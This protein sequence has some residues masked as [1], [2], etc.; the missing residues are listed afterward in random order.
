[1][2]RMDR[3]DATAFAARRVW[4]CAAVVLAAA[5]SLLVMVAVPAAAEPSARANGDGRIGPT[6]NLNAA[7]KTE[8]KDNSYKLGKATVTGGLSS[9]VVI[10]VDNGWF[11]MPRPSIGEDADAHYDVSHALDAHGDF[12]SRDEL[13]RGEKHTFGYRYVVFES[14]RT[15]DITAK[16]IETHL[17]SLTF[18]LGGSKTQTVSVSAWYNQP[19]AKCNYRSGSSEDDGRN[20][21]AR[22]FNGHAYAFIEEPDMPFDEAF[23]AAKV[24]TFVGSDGHL[25][26]IE[27]REEHNL[28]H[29]LFE[30]RG[31]G[32]GWIGGQR[33]I[34]PGPNRVSNWYWVAGPSAGIKFW[35]GETGAVPGVFAQWANG[36]PSSNE[37]A[38]CVQYGFSD[39]ADSSAA[40]NA[41]TVSGQRAGKWS[42]GE[43]TRANYIRG[44]YVEF[45]NF[46]PSTIG[47]ASE[48]SKMVA[49]KSDLLDVTSSN[50]DTSMLSG[51]EY[52]TTLTAADGRDLD[53]ASIQVMVG[54]VPLS[55]RDNGF[56]FNLKSDK[57]TAEL[58]IPA[59]KVTGDVTVTAKANRLVTLQD[60]WTSRV[61]AIVQV[62]NGVTL[63]RKDLDQHVKTKAGYT[64][65]G[66]TK[67]GAEWDFGT[68]VTVDMT[69]NPQ[70]KL[71]APT[72][73]IW[74]PDPRLDRR[75]ATVTLHVSA[76]VDGVPNA[77]FTY[78]W[79]KDG[80]ALPGNT[81][82]TLAATDAGTYMVGVTAT[83][84]ATKLT[85]QGQAT[86]EVTA[87]HQR[88]VTLQ[89]QDGFSWLTKQFTVTN[90]DKL[91]RN[92]L[93]KKV[94]WPGYTVVEY[95]KADGTQ[96]PFEA[97]VRSDVTLHPQYEMIAPTVT[98]TASPSKLMSVGDKSTLSA[99]V[100]TLVGN[101]E[102]GY[103]WSKGGNPIAG[104]TG[105]SYKT[106]EP[107]DYMVTVTVTDP[108]TN[109]SSKGTASVTLAAPDRHMVT[110][111][112]QDGSK[113]YLTVKVP[114]GGLLDA[115]M[116]SG[117][118]RDGHVLIGWMK[119]DGTKFD[120]T[121][122]KITQ[123][124]VI[125]PEWKLVESAEPVKP[126][127]PAKPTK[128]AEPAAKTALVDTGLAVSA[129]AVALVLMLV[130][131]VVA[132]GLR[133]RRD[134]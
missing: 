127:K 33:V 108:K 102:I 11:E 65:V 8:A 98:A 109:M 134:K 58:K 10:E 54:G 22:L 57:R 5:A 69:L 82:G 118:T 64:H 55:Q 15:A 94:T 111:V 93:D 39:E 71:K 16:A 84:P 63:E 92:D 53:P 121:Q 110:V 20:P 132:A 131:A 112:E 128:P 29:R 48:V 74:T 6:V 120:P 103:Q 61:L 40:W 116:L 52:S 32:T 7:Q 4:R 47:R 117:I 62:P 96:W 44:F 13:S 125:S 37:D 30:K 107:G 124:E 81:A 9:Y 88:T 83:D 101:G 24:T 86:I 50:A 91:D 49:V 56:T 17:R 45:E 106:G 130:A 89:G 77:T 100:T 36:Q 41:L 73:S 28:V 119:A 87:P 129:P 51:T 19:E 115:N 35:S 18:Y 2:L 23:L 38:C 80:A 27:S 123:N 90:G 133:Q 72:V 104:A 78:E 76:Q 79:S 34:T 60:A 99:Q 42:A 26:T 46:H 113:T 68:P 97:E 31:G 126:A 85:S 95:T 1:M 3:M 122:D 70:W 43:Q 14:Y 21:K 105:R 12:L 75:G 114:H 59:E 67:H 25:M 66:Y